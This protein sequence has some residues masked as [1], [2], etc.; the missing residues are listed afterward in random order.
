M[1]DPRFKTAAFD[2]CGSPDLA[3]YALSFFSCMVKVLE[4]EE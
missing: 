3:L 2:L 4:I 1:Y